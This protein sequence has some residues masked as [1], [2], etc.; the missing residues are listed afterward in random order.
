MKSKVLLLVTVLLTLAILGSACV[1]QPAVPVEQPEEAAPAEEPEEAMPPAE[2][3]EATFV[4]AWPYTVPPTGHFNAYV[5]NALVLGIYRDLMEQPLAMYRWADDSWMPI[6]ATEW[7]L[8]PPDTFNVTLRD[9]VTWSDGTPFTAEDV[10][11][12][13][14][15]GRLMNYTVWQYVDSV[16]AVDDHTVSFHMSVP[17]TVVPRYVLRQQIVADSVYGEWADEAQAM[18]DEGLERDSDEMQALRQE[19]EAFRPDGLVVTG[20]FNVD[21]NSITESQLTL[22]K[23]PTAWNA[24]QVGFDQIV[25][26]NGETPTVTPVVLAKEV[27]Y[28]THG[29]PPATEAQ[30]EAEGIRILRPPIYTGPALYFNQDIYPFN[31]TAVRQA[32]AYAVDRDENA[33]VSLGESALRQ[34][35]MAGFSD[36]LVPLWIS[37]DTLADL[38]PY[39]FDPA[40]AETIF[41]ELGFTRADDGVWVDDQ[42]NRMEYELTAP[43]EFADWSA[44]AEN[45]AEQ[46]TEFGIQT[47]VRGVTFT[48]HPTDVRQGNFELAIRDW[49]AGHPHPH[50]SYVTDFFAYNFV[51]A[52]IP[53]SNQP[54]SA[55]GPGMNFPLEQETEVMGEVD[56]ADL[57]V[58][59]AEGLDEEA[60]K[61]QITNL[62]LVYNELLPQ[63]PLWERYGNNPTPPGVRVAGWPSDDAPIMQNSPYADS[64]VIMM[65][66]DGTLQPPQ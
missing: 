64:F 26:Y 42:G 16:E 33:T 17:S 36:N 45:L 61:E 19:F 20:P 46:L 38:N 4:G 9:G 41:E 35:Y 44:A 10:I 49:G 5:T 15:L 65:I 56:L 13:F 43:A 32:I 58:T 27:D 34:R 29:F 7:E 57:V 24:D 8:V 53:G 14:T 2:A 39:D 40:R 52:P 62:A 28:A 30:F 1:T 50:F 37:E 55:A 6:L 31:V 18:F 11:T 66:L 21:P 22:V 47:T 23:V 48:Q 54:Q 3:G 51:S 63:I 59:A 25:L 60:Q 12:T